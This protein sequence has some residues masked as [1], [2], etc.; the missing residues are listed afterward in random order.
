MLTLTV[1]DD[2]KTRTCC[3]RHV[4][5]LFWLLEMC[6]LQCVT[7]RYHGEEAASVPAFSNKKGVYLLWSQILL[8]T[9]QHRREA[10]PVL[11]P[12]IPLLIPDQWPAC[13]PAGGGSSSGEGLTWD[14]WES[15]CLPDRCIYTQRVSD[16]YTPETQEV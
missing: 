11:S 1:R 14:R 15:L 12:Y 4:G 9:P 10:V 5:L 7:D 6:V 16:N 2:I 3:G 8:I 13:L